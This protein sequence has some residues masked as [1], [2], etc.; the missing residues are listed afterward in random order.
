MDVTCILENTT[1]GWI[2]H[3]HM[4]KC[5]VRDYVQFGPTDILLTLH[6]QHKLEAGWGI[7]SIAVIGRMGYQ[8]NFF[9]VLNIETGTRSVEWEIPMHGRPDRGLCL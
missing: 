1:R 7:N 6:L 9:S 5:Q 8:Y 2:H 4:W 3:R